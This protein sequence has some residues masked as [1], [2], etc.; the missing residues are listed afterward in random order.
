MEEPI[1]LEGLS[2]ITASGTLSSPDEHTGII[3]SIEMDLKHHMGMEEEL[4]HKLGVYEQAQRIAHAP[5]SLHREAHS[6][7]VDKPDLTLNM[8]GQRYNSFQ[9]RE[10]FISNLTIVVFAF[11]VSVL[12]FLLFAAAVGEGITPVDYFTRAAVIGRLLLQGN[13]SIADLRVSLQKPVAHR[14]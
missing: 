5:C 12:L 10:P 9:A 1:R 6:L 4:A 7:L 8:K 11:I 2:L 13:S 14:I 3:S